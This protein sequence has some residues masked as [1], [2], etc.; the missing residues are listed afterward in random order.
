MLNKK[1]TESSK[2]GK[3]LLFLPMIA[4]SLLVVNCTQKVDESMTD[5]AE[6]D[7]RVVAYGNGWKIVK[8]DEKTNV[9]MPKSID[10]TPTFDIVEQ[11]PEFPGGMQALMKYL[12]QSIKYPTQAQEAGIQG[13]VIVQFI[14]NKDGTISDA[15]LARGVEPSLD[16]EAIRIVKAMPSWTPGLQKGQPVNVRFTLP[17]AF[18]L[19]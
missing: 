19:Q 9:E 17:V 15:T 10:G 11:M 16:D 14:V 6:V 13:R 3:S 12:A 1:R 2:I 7:E 8:E 18:R 5:G 4:L